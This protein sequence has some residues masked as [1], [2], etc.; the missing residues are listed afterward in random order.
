MGASAADLPG[1]GAS[2]AL[3]L[4]SLAVVCLLAYVALRWLARRGAGRSD[5]PVRVLARCSLEPRRAVYLV[6]VAGRCFLVGVGDGPMSLLAEIDP[7]AVKDQVGV[8]APVAGGLRFAD[9]LSR[10]RGRA[11]P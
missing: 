9:V 8:A 3:S 4:L 5:G 7:A 6:Q 10:F 2:F 11:K 1:L